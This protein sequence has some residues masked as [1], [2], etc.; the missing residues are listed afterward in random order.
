MQ[1]NEDCLL[2]IVF[3]V[4]DLII[5]GLSYTGLREIKSGLRK[6][7]SMAELFLLRQFIGLKVN[8]ID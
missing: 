8:Q 2:L 4:G 1:K 7:F 5:T 6:Y 3:C